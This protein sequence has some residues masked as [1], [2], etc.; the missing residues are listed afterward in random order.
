MYSGTFETLGES[1]MKLVR[2]YE[3]QDGKQFDCK[4]AAHEHEVKIATIAAI[5]ESLQI[6]IRTGR[7]DAVIQQMVE[8]ATTVRSILGAMATKMPKKRRIAS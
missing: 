8:E 2:L 1:L 6:S 4:R 5:R 7:V 3:T